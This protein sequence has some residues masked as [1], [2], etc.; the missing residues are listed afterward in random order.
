M[1]STLL[2]R[3]VR[4]AALP[5][6]LVCGFLLWWN[7]GSVVVPV[8]MDTMTAEFPPGTLCI[9]DKRPPPLAAGQVVWFTVDG[10]VLLSRV[11]RVDGDQF[12]VEHDNARSRFADGDELGPLPRSALRSL[13]LSSFRG[14]GG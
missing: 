6:A 12:W 14:E 9:V 5:T 13:V 10:G 7:F 8:G 3:I 2:T 1:N 4:R 11:S